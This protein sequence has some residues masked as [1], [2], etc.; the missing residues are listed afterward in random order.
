MLSRRDTQCNAGAFNSVAS[1][2]P[3]YKRACEQSEE[4]KYVPSDQ[5]DICKTPKGLEGGA[6]RVNVDQQ[7]T[8][9]VGTLLGFFLF[10]ELLK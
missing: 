2:Q 8:K 7:F 5:R 1:E 4:Q 10:A 6:I 9:I 3:I